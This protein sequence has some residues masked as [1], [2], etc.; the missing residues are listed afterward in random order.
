[1]PFHKFEGWLEP[2]PGD[3]PGLFSVLDTEQ[4]IRYKEGMQPAATVEALRQFLSR[5]AP[6]YGQREGKKSGLDA[7]DQ[8]LG[9]GLPKG[10]IVVLTG[11]R[12]AGRLTLAARIAAE[13]TK[14]S[15]PI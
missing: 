4:I 5:T 10:A 12:G 2:C 8:L 11:E 13:E 9:Q 15:R 6:F 7:L 3:D 14:A 1:I